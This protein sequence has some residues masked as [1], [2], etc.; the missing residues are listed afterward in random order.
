MSLAVSRRNVL[1]NLAGVAAGI[2]AAPSGGVCKAAVQNV[3]A[4]SSAPKGYDPSQHRWLMALDVGRCIGCGRCVEACK[5][6]N[7]V[8]DSHFRTWIERYIITKPKPGSG[9]TRGETIVDSPDGGME[10]FPEALVPKEDILKSFFVPKLC[11]LCEHSPCA[12][13]C[14][15]G[16]TFEAP[17]GVVLVDRNYCIGCGFC[18]QA[19]PYGCRFINPETHTADKCT[20]CYHRITRGLKPACV[21]V[22]PSQARIFGDLR[23]PVPD[24]PLRQFTANNTVEGLKRN[25]GTG[26]RVAY[27]GLDEEVR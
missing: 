1:K 2:L 17:D 10:G 18:V 20:L 22:C 5:A 25:L 6:E 15:V 27:A 3:F 21:E 24:D 14:P 11:N 12:Q 9:D 16:A 13:V 19:C 7:N 23:N 26:P 4:I 8:P